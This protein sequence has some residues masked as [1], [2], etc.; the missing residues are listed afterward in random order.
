MMLGAPP[1]FLSG[2]TWGDVVWL[3]L[4]VILL[5]G[6]IVAS[7][8]QKRI[9]AEKDLAILRSTSLPTYRQTLR[10]IQRELD[11][12]RRFSRP[13]TMVV[14]RVENYERLEVGYGR[15]REDPRQRES[16]LIA[17]CGSR[18]MFA[19]VGL[20][21]QEGLRE[22]DLVTLDVVGRRYVVV[23][24]ECARSEASSLV[25]R[26]ERLVRRGTGVGI[27]S[28]VAE[29]GADG[30]IVSDLLTKATE[31]CENGGKEEILSEPSDEVVAGKSRMLA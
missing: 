21:L 6:G 2:F 1:Q 8:R 19:H 30:L 4:V 3:L 12:A 17:A 15:R 18:I 16:R 25:T 13:L 23:L 14:V 28:G 11:R 26:L 27:E 5:V 20:I 22:M 10:Q 31:R 9:A 7:W 24:P 29:V